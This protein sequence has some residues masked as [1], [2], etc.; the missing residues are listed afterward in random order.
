LSRSVN[1]PDAH[2]P[3]ESFESKSIAE[4]LERDLVPAA[5]SGIR[6][7]PPDP[8]KTENA[9]PYQYDCIFVHSTLCS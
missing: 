3:S 2:A 1:E 4:F 7:S 5:R 6:P 8:K 9:Y